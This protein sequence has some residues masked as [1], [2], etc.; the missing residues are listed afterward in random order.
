MQGYRLAMAPGRPALASL[1]AA[2]GAVHLV[3][4]P[5]HW[6]ESV[7]EGVG[8]AAAGWL[9]L[10]LAALLLVRP[11]RR[12][13]A[14]TVTVNVG[15]VATW[16]WSRTVGGEEATFV[17]LTVV[18]LEVALVAGALAV[19]A[20]PDLRPRLVVTAAVPVASL[21]L[22][23]AAVASPSARNHAHGGSDH[24]EAA[25]GHAHDEPA[26]DDRG[27]SALSNGHHHAIGP[28]QPLDRTTRSALAHQISL[29][30]QVAARYPTVA[31]V[32]AGGYNRVGPYIP[33]IGAHYIR[34]D[35]TLNPDGV[36]DDQDA[37]NPLAIIFEGTDPEARIAGFMYYSV[38]PDEP[39][40]FAGPNDVWHYHTNICL[41]PS[42]DGALDAP[43]GTDVEVPG[44]LCARSGGELVE[45]TQWMV[46]VWSVPG[47]ESQQGLFGEVNPGLACADGSYHVLP[48]EQWIE[49]PLDA[50]ASSAAA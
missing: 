12:V 31:D 18:G 30:Q 42:A 46:H 24:E 34:T 27:L 40:G 49:S 32:V 35:G 44:D 25:T 48:M 2:A 9:Q 11:E 7:A 13:F 38:S 26:V 5:D 3:M 19:L 16:A 1:S 21:L 41:R 43:F 29:S 33:G 23:T 17:D 10:A 45:Q 39:A 28:E 6:G 20:R 37:L 47:W 8:F 4:V 36:V 22:A 14:A 50:C 15:L